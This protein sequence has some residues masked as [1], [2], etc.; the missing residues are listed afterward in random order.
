[1][2]VSDVIESKGAYRKGKNFMI[3]WHVNR[4]YG[5]ISISKEKIEIT[6]HVPKA[7]NQSLHVILE[8]D[9]IDNIDIKGKKLL[10]LHH[11]QGQSRYIAFWPKDLDLILNGL[12]TFGYPVSIR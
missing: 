7:S 12:K 4:P 8:R 3:S 6:S 10:I 9:V 1:M 11:N 5:K 2:A